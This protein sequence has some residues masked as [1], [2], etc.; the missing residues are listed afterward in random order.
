MNILSGISNFFGLEIGNSAIRLVELTGTGPTK[1]LVKYAYAPVDSKL[2]ASDSKPDQ[3]RLSRAVADLIAQAKVSTKNVA[4][5]LPSSKVFSTVVD[6]DRLPPEELGK[7]LRYQADT[8]IP[9]PID[10]SKID[11]AVLGDSPTDRTKLEL[12]I[13]SVDNTYVEKQLDLLEQIGLNVIAFEPN[14]IALARALTAPDATMP[15]MI[16][17]INERHT[18]LVIVMNGAPRLTRAIPTGSEAIV[19]AAAQNLNIDEKQAEQ[20]VFKFGLGKD[21]LEGRVYEAVIGT[22]DVLVSEVEKSIKF[23]QSR[24]TEARLDRIIVTGGASSMPEF[25]VYIANR[26]GLNVEIGNAWRNVS[27]SPD[28][29]NE[30]LSVSNHFGTVVGIAER[31]TV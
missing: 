21:K 23:F 27:F 6:F 31:T 3:Q 7:A 19:R 17:D 30:L 22:V 4:V 8:I 24:Y 18:D 29:Q 28:R 25:P 11:F 10:Q 9:T 16:I 2:V 15:Q 12:F 5:S 1:S 13:S 20:F 14:H 26:F